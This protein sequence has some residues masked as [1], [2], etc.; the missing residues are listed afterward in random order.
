MFPELLLNP[1]N[2][3]DNK[4]IS[5]QNF[6]Q[7]IIS[8][9]EKLIKNLPYICQKAAIDL[10]KQ[11]KYKEASKEFKKIYL[12]TQD[13]HYKALFLHT[14]AM[15][16]QEGGKSDESIAKNFVALKLVKDEFFKD[17]IR[18]ELSK[19]LRIQGIEFAKQNDFERA[20]ISIG[21]SVKL[22]FN[23]DER[24][25][26][27]DFFESLGRLAIAGGRFDIAIQKYIAVY[28]ITNDSNYKANIVCCRGLEIINKVPTTGL[29]WIALAS[30]ICSPDYVDRKF[31]LE[32]YTGVIKAFSIDQEIKIAE[33]MSIDREKVIQK[34]DK[35]LY[36]FLDIDEINLD[37]EVLVF[38]NVNIFRIQE[39]LEEQNL[40]EITPLHIA[41]F[42]GQIDEV[43][44]ILEDKE[45]DINK[46]TIGGDT[47][48]HL[49]VVNGY[50]EIVELFLKHP[51]INIALTC[52]DGYT[53]LE[54]SIINSR[55]EILELFLNYDLDLKK[56]DYLGLAFEN[57]SYGT[58]L[59]FY[60]LGLKLD[61]AG[62]VY[63]NISV[64]VNDIQYIYNS[65]S[66]IYKIIGGIPLLNDLEKQL[67]FTNASS[68]IKFLLVELHKTITEFLSNIH[69]DFASKSSIIIDL[70]KYSKILPYL[71][72]V[73]KELLAQDHDDGICFENVPCV[74]LVKYSDLPR[75]YKTFLKDDHDQ[76]QLF[77]DITDLLDYLN[78]PETQLLGF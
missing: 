24:F 2:D 78:Q 42:W 17:K 74:G 61:L 63:Q 3:G 57:K 52:D 73:C 58:I 53:A 68:A 11:K 71:V 51:C 34:S 23:G 4:G 70:A 46:Q 55:L 10:C 6:A 60:S 26:I 40:L 14:H 69:K 22:K 44:K 41:A 59:L 54:L 45:I 43:K 67:S 21:A 66:D 8:G 56:Q 77:K 39:S 62:G 16:L 36:K 18:Y 65:S 32:C 15:I 35:E 37:E 25:G 28:Q 9:E 48:L 29:C 27:I 50:L 49:S 19:S 75:N 38:E 47:A 1:T 64:L 31:F 72:E 13:D 76:K 20:A 7:E 12:T 5:P 30:T 33:I